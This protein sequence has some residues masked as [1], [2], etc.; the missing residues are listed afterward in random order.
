MAATAS[1]AASNPVSGAASGQASHASATLD[2]ILLDLAGDRAT[3]S[4]R[5]GKHGT[6]Y[7]DEGR[8]SYVEC[9]TTPSVE[10]I[11]TASGRAT[12]TRIRA[13]RQ[14]ASSA[15]PANGSAGGPANA[16]PAG[17][18]LPNGGELLVRQ[19][20]LSRGELQ[21]CV[22]GATLD[23][24]YFLL[25][26]RPGRP[27]FKA[28]DRHWLG[29]HWFFDIPGLLLDCQKR[30]ARLDRVWPSAEVDICPVTPVKR[31]QRGG[32][33]VLSALQWEV[34]AE[35]DGATPPIA[36]AHRIRR[37]VYATLLAVRELAASGL[38]TGAQ[39][40]AKSELPRRTG[41]SG[42]RP[43]AG[44]GPGHHAPAMPQVSG[45]PADI[46]LLIRLRDALE[47]LR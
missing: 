3:G 7:L 5:V 26:E 11:L 38:V 29:T 20:V 14:S 17:A 2:S 33:V 37:P 25:P 19:G 47:A 39:Q 4:L 18:A 13:I 45:D 43:G 8:I 46:Q 12:V 27:R 23:A 31:L 35:A 44:G 40:P 1:S 16:A 15:A 24:A 9:A 6:V 30:K 42:P 28:G 41:G 36:L 21:F 10:E 22:L 32:H 34:L